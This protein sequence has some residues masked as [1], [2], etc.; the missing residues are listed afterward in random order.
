MSVDLG[1]PVPRE[2]ARSKQVVSQFE[3]KFPKVRGWPVNSKPL[4]TER[5]ENRQ[6]PGFA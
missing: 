1:D 2:K 5:S 3:S 6:R 4:L